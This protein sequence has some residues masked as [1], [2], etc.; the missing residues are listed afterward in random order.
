MEWEHHSPEFDYL[1]NGVNARVLPHGTTAADFGAAVA[2]LLADPAAID[3][4]RDG[5]RVAAETYTLEAMVANFAT[6]VLAAVD[7]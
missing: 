4:L 7:G 5:C 6:G 3:R 1:E 2:E